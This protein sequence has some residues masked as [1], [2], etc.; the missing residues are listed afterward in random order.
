MADVPPPAR[1][2]GIRFIDAMPRPLFIV[3]VVAGVVAVV[4]ALIFIVHPPEPSTV[5]VAERAPPPHGTLSHDVGK[6]N[7]LPVP[8]P[9]PAIAP[10]CEAV[11]RT[12]LAAGPAGVARLRSVLT[13]V[14]RLASGGVAPEV[15]TAVEGLRGATVR[16]A[17]FERAGVEST[18]DLATRTIWLNIKFSQESMPVEEVVPVLLHD[19]WNLAHPKEAVTAAQELGARRA[20]VG[21]CREL[22][23][24]DKWPRWCNDA[25]TLTDLPEATAI[26]AL[27]SAGYQR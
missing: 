4:A 5:P 11:A 21:A 17:G 1:D 16:F 6:L 26:N 7:P 8:T 23:A 18:A 3:F 25:R 10:P 19:A 20:E 22:I 9:L 24:I 15:T 27:V 14:C 2:R 12:T 13:D